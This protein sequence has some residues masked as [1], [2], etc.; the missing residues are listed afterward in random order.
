MMMALFDLEGTFMEDSDD[1]I[2]NSSGLY[3]ATRS[4]LIRRGY[5]CANKCLNCPYVN[6]RSSSTWKPLDASMIRT[7]KVSPKVLEGVRQTL[8]A[9]EWQVQHGSQSEEAFHQE[10]ITHYRLLLKR[11][12]ELGG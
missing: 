12:K 4:F 6:W 1:W 8:A 7:A 2:I 3:V 11:W 10:M 9:H 5:C